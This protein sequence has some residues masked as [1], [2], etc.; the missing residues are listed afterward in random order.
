M[1]FTLMLLLASAISAG[2]EPTWS[3]AAVVRRAGQPVVRFQARVDGDYLFVR[4]THEKE[5]HTY[6]MDNEARSARAL[7]GKKS[8][9]FEQGVDIKVKGG[10][11]ID[12]QWLQTRPLDLSKPELRWY[13]YGFE[14][15][16]IFACRIKTVTA[17]PIIMQIRGQA[18]SRESCLN[19]DVV[20]ELETR[21]AVDD[22][23]TSQVARRK[24][25]LKDM[26]PIVHKS[27]TPSDQPSD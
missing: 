15:T 1:I 7:N 16:V 10:L 5:W 12:D 23:S 4:A 21:P 6:A 14:K 11:V 9:G 24:T 20:L 25:M 17:E 13:T 26:V 8:L 3:K 19:I 18:C 27:P 2:D 22:Q